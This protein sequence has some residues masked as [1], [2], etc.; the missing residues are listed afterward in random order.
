MWKE[1]LITVP[2]WTLNA[3]YDILCIKIIKGLQYTH[4]HKIKI[5]IQLIFKVE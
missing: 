3:T 4:T 5:N 2:S 1:P